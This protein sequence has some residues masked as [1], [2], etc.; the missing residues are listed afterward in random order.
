MNEKK[1]RR[2][3][4]E[5][6]AVFA[7]K[8]S[9]IIFVIYSFFA[10]GLTPFSSI[11]SLCHSI[12]ATSK[13]QSKHNDLPCSACHSGAGFSDRLNF[14]LSLI[15]MPVFTLFFSKPKDA[16]VTDVT[17]TRCHLTQMKTSLVSTN[18]VKVSHA[19]II[20]GGYECVDCHSTTGHLFPESY[21]RQVD[22]FEC[23]HC[24]NG[25]VVSVECKVC[26]PK[27]GKGEK[28]AYR[29]NYQVVHN[30]TEK[31]HGIADL[32][33]CSNCHKKEDCT[34]CHGLEMP[35][36]G[37]FLYIHSTYAIS[38]YFK[39]ECSRCHSETAFCLS[40][41]QMEMPHPDGFLQEHSKFSRKDEEK[42]LRCHEKSSCL[43]CHSRH[44]HPGIPTE[45]LKELRRRFRLE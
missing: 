33:T 23:F 13:S 18:G 2:E 38:P 7:A 19:E 21:G 20:T 24:H 39:K 22:M 34:K 3:E 8:V 30:E 35:H 11:C 32:N 29:T 40:C 43:W 17:C 28:R 14:R 16:Q 44:R 5:K 15:R 12:E 26:H 1:E 10:M 37:E 45:V 27:T 9:L 25:V 42:C 36:P 41:H 4:F 31:A 6:Q